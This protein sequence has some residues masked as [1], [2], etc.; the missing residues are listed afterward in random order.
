MIQVLLNVFLVV[1]AVYI[2]LLVRNVNVLKIVHILMDMFVLNAY[3]I[4]YITLLLINV[5]VVILIVFLT[6][7]HKFV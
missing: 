1:M 7:K 5:K 4:K 6:R 2:I 3:N